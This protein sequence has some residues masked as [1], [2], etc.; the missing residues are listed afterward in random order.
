MDDEK[1]RKDMPKKEKKKAQNFSRA[2]SAQYL[3][4]FFE[5]VQRNVVHFLLTISSFADWK[6]LKFFGVENNN[7]QSV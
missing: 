4:L 2:D 3:F 1:T 6:S 5:L 7:F